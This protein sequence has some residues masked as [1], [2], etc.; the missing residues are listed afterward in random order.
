MIFAPLNTKRIAPLSTCCLGKKTGNLW[1]NLNVGILK[2]D[3]V[4]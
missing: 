3:Q 1:N 2:K 4:N